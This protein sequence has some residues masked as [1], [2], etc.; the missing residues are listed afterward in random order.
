MANPQQGQPN[1]PNVKEFFDQATWTLTY[2]AFDPATRDAVVIDPVWDYDPAS[3]KTSNE[4]T[5]QVLS[6]IHREGLKVHFIL[7]THAH[8]DHLTGAQVLKRHLSGAK[9]G[10]GAQIQAVQ[11]VFKGV[12]NF[13]D[14][15]ATDGRQFDILLKE[16]EPLQA[17]SLT[18]KTIFTPGHTP[19]C[20]SYLIGDAVFTGD[21]LFMPDY[22][23]G[24]CDFPAGS[25]DELYTSVHEKLYKL[26]DSTR[27]FVGHD[28]Q[29]DGRGLAF[30]STIAEEK[31]GNIHLRAD[32]K[33]EEF[34]SLRTTRD[35]R[36]AA[37]RLLLQSVQVNINAGVLPSA[38]SNGSRYL[39][40]P[41]R[42]S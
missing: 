25:A 13:G 33:R 28:Y 3:S 27:V 32:T 4:S 38:D 11:K 16:G 31:A 35:K 17:G 8:A 39:R 9:V 7:E 30:Q 1:A 15:F 12:F 6:Y 21:A 40:I 34:V 23:T 36:L 29:P 5:E 18:I 10:I 22:G 2:V 41:V 14:E 37:P 26:P 24:R 20:A 42:Q 19:A